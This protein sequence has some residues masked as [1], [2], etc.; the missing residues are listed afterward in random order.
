MAKSNTAV[1]TLSEE[2][3]NALDHEILDVLSD[4]RATPTLVKRLLERND[5]DVSRQYINRR[6]KRLSEHEHIEN[7]LDTGVYELTADIRKNAP[8]EE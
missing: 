8:S 2:D 1:M 6:M 5:T 4:G 7:L 3:L